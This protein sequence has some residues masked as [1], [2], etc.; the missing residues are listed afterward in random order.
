VT[1]DDAGDDT[2]RV[3]DGG[4]RVIC[5]HCA[6]RTVFRYRRRHTIQRLVVDFFDGR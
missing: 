6:G 1:L 5:S 4:Y 3:K 2:R